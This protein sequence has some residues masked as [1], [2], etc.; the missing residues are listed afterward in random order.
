MKRISLVAL[1]ALCV[2][3]ASASSAFAN[4][5]PHG[6]YAQ[7]TDACAGCHRAHTSFSSLGWTDQQGADRASAL[8]VANATSMTEF[9]YVCHGNAAPGASTNVQ[10][11]VFDAGPTADGASTPNHSTTFYQSFST[12]G[13]ALNGGGFERIGG[14][15]GATIQSSHMMDAYVNASPAL[16]AVLIRWG[17]ASL[18]P[19]SKFTCTDCHDPHGSSNYRLLKDQLTGAG[20]M[21]NYVTSNEKNFP[22][23]GFSR[24]AT[25][26]QQIAEYVPNYTSA[27]YAKSNPSRGMSAWCS[28]CHSNYDVAD[29]VAGNSAGTYDYT[30]NG[31]PNGAASFPPGAQTFH[32]HLMGVAL[33][34]NMGSVADGRALSVPV[35]DD[36]GLPLEMGVGVFN[37]DATPSGTDGEYKLAKS[38]DGSGYISCLTCH[39]AHGTASTMGGWA[40]ASIDASGYP[41]MVATGTPSTAMAPHDTAT[42]GMGAA[43][44]H[45]SPTNI[46]GVNP[47]FS[48]DML[49]YPNRG[50]CERCHNK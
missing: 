47:S 32:R 33:D 49:R 13:A 7:D 21:T 36:A 18:A 30:A 44:G 11:G 39:R 17:N 29:G 3:L 31:N 46:Q 41:S 28:G 40:I 12:M 8:L 19:M 4:F 25:G 10:A 22:A 1:L 16:Q 26:A 5:G 14:A 20:D 35:Q 34:P 2:L 15:M 43:G 45:G 23:A 24:G 48:Q 37:R 9:C 38:W 6:G 42:K 50:V 27:Y